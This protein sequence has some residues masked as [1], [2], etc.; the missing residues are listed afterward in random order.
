MPKQP[1]F[2]RAVKITY[3]KRVKTKSVGQ[4]HI[5]RERQNVANDIGE[6]PW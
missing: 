4:P 1:G 5:K 3:G 2:S 6:G